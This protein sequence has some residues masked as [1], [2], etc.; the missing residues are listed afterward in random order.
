MKELIWISIILSSILI[1][2]SI[3]I[4]KSNINR[5]KRSSY[6]CGYSIT[7]IVPT[8]KIYIKYFVI[9][10]LYLIFDLE[11]IILYPLI[12][13][14]NNILII[15]IFMTIIVIGLAFEIKSINSL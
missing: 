1:T 11:T 8:K 5:E 9:G 2:I 7:K 13:A 6:E 15:Y 3:L 14:N 10:F 4:N 12:I